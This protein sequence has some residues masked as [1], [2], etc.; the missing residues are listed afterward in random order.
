M[1]FVWI[2]EQTAIISLHS[3]NWLVFITETECVYCAVRTGYLYIILRSAHTVYLC[4]LCGS[5]NK[6]RLFPYTALTDWFLQLIRSAFTAQYGLDIHMNPFTFLHAEV[7][8]YLRTDCSRDTPLPCYTIITFSAR[9]PF[10]EFSSHLPISNARCSHSHFFPYQRICFPLPS[11]LPLL[12]VRTFHIE[13]SR[14]TTAM[15][16]ASSAKICVF[17]NRTIALSRDTSRP[18]EYKR[19]LTAKTATTPST[20]DQH[21]SRKTAQ[22]NNPFALW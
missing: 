5:E 16:N 12:Y 11:F 2:W 10:C 9:V 1:Y 21:I 7:K 20:I 14:L 8:K 4:V 18:L 3:I 19:H 22:R 15:K 17:W 6:Q 13:P